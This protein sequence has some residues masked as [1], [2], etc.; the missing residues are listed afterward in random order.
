[1]SRT[2]ALGLALGVVA[3]LVFADPRR[4][5]PVAGF[6]RVAAALERR[7]Y[8]DS[9]LAGAGYA[10]VLVGGAVLAG[11]GLRRVAAGEPGPVADH[12]C[13]A[14]VRAGGEVLVT[15]AATWAVLGGTSLVREG[16]GLASSLDADDL[17][18]ARAR[19]PHL[20]ARDPES[21][22]AAGMARAGVESL[23]ENTSDAV[24]A[25]LF[26]GAVAGVPGLLGYRAVNTLDAMVGYRS[27]R[28]LRFGWAPARLDD[29]ANLVPARL[30]ALL[31][32]A[33][34]PVV[35]GRPAAALRAWR[36]DAREHPSPN[37]GPVEAAAAG[38]LAIRL[39]GRTEYTHGTEERPSLGDGPAPTTADLHRAARLSRA[40][41]LLAAVVTAAAAAPGR[42]RTTRPGC[43]PCAR[44]GRAAAGPRGGRSTPGRPG[45]WRRR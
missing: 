14:R 42:G 23:A 2:R 6:G 37:A 22:D 34:A 32:A 29:L 7:V 8:A 11:V 45:R 19:I 28:Y 30:A 35:G 5:H 39:G 17:A 3:D 4:G 33:A 36:R 21:L 18:A 41:G 26:W 15:A 1:M 10:A 31:T 13:S 43:S 16:A 44:G 27:P 38:A 20:C 9:R 12:L 40:V 25:P 24:V